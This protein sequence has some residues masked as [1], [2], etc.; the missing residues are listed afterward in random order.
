MR[1]P[2][3]V[4]RGDVLTSWLTVS[5][6]TR[7]RLATEI[8]VSKGRISQLLTSKEEPS[9]HLI[10]KLLLLTRLPFDR[11]FKIVPE[12]SQSSIQSESSDASASRPARKHREALASSSS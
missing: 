9:A 12:T 1:L 10:A 7:S 6:Y 11:L 5:D 2:S 8:G 4:V 3:V